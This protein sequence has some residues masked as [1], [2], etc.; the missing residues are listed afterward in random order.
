ML[1]GSDK[2]TQKDYAP[3]SLVKGDIFMIVGATLYGFSAWSCLFPP[4]MFMI[5][6]LWMACVANATEELFVRKSP[7]YEAS[8]WV[9]ALSLSDTVTCYLGSGNAW[10]VGNDHQRCPSGRIRAQ[11]MDDL[12]LGRARQ[13]VS[14]N[15]LLEYVVTDPTS[16]ASLRVYCGHVHIVHRGAVDIQARLLCVLQHQ[17]ANERLLR[18]AVRSISLREPTRTLFCFSW[19]SADAGSGTG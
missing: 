7:L 12:Q 4:V 5:L 8:R 6:T 10:D 2:L 15:V 9:V 13:Y 11:V 16:W 14:L 18:A 3:T 19:H 1:V 17:S